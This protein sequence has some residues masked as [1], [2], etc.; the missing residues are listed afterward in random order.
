[1]LHTFYRPIASNALGEGALR[2][3]EQFEEARRGRHGTGHALSPRHWNGSEDVEHLIASSVAASHADA[4]D[5]EYAALAGMADSAHD[6][7]TE[8]LTPA[9]LAEFTRPLNPPTIFGIGVILGVDA[10][11]RVAKALFVTPDGPADGV[12]LESG[13]LIESVN[14][15][16]T[17]GLPQDRVSGMLRGPADSTVRVEYETAAHETRSAAI[18]RSVVRVPTVF[19]NMVP[20][21]SIGYVYV[22]AFGRP[23]ADEFTNALNR[24]QGKMTGLILDLRDDG[25][26][27]LQA[28]VS[29]ASHF[30]SSGPIVSTV[31]R[32]A[33]VITLDSDDEKPQ[34]VVP[35][36]LLV[37][38]YT[39]SASEIVAGALQDT[40]AA[41]LIGTR[42][43]G[44]G[45]EQSLTPLPDGSAIKITTA[46][47]LTP[48]NRDVNR[49]G[50]RPDY[51]CGGNHQY[52]LFQEE[53]DSD[54]LCA[55]TYLKSRPG[56]PG[57]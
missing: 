4:R 21:T 53:Q 24:L 31:P 13:D 55:V 54:I 57:V 16:P 3:V 20:H 27:Y 47:Y 43:Y 49:V 51:G 25:G 12:G 32:D 36:V 45:V 29:I 38:R 37:N 22:A 7:W 56:A 5:V 6:R 15:I 52:S 30:V 41:V 14:G 2:G 26:G 44:K 17:R 9:E 11:T 42:T 39:A 8:F 1:M 46:R 40:G 10:P 50:L 35:T 34:V 23:T 28:A 19:F 48:L 18:K 33:P